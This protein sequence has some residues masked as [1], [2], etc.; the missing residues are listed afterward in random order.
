MGKL[1]HSRCVDW[2]SSFC[3]TLNE[4]TRRVDYTRALWIQVDVSRLV[5]WARALSMQLAR[6][7][8]GAKYSWVYTRPGR[9]EELGHQVVSGAAYNH[10]ILIRYIFVS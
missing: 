9:Q 7:V 8:Q 3:S 4:Q 10:Q 5:I 2:I 1:V 6:P